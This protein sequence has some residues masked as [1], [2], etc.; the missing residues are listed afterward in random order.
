M[1]FGT[2]SHASLDNFV[3]LL[4]FPLLDMIFLKCVQIFYFFND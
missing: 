3:D 4:T 2:D 1:N